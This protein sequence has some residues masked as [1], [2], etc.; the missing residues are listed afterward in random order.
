MVSESL[1]TV[2]RHLLEA[3]KAF[4][5]QTALIGGLGMA[6][7][8]HVRATKDVNLLVDLEKNRRTRITG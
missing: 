4:P 6:A 3:L 7:R 1:I 2:L 8:R 5:V